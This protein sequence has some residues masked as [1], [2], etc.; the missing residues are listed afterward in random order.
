MSADFGFTCS[1]NA[2]AG[3][4]QVVACGD[5]IVDLITDMVDAAGWVFVQESLNWAVFT[6]RV[7]Q[8]DFGVGQFDENYSYPMIGF[9]L[10]RADICAQCGAVL[11][12]GCL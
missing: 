8:F 2:R 7:Q 3:G 6:Q 9:V 4:L 1:Q 11:V 10:W 12:G 5:D